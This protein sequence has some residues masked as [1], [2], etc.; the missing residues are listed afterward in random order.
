ME[1]L[2]KT[3]LSLR[4]TLVISALNT[5]ADLSEFLP[6]GA[7]DPYCVLIF[8]TLLKCASSTKKLLAETSHSTLLTY[9]A[10]SSYNPKALSLICSS[11]SDRSVQ[12]RI[13]A[14]SYLISFLTRHSNKPQQF[15]KKGLQVGLELVK[16]GLSRSLGDA[17]PKA[18]ELARQAFS[19]FQNTWPTEAQ[20]LLKSLDANARKQ[21]AHAAPDSSSTTAPT[22]AAQS[23]TRLGA[24]RTRAT[25]A[26]STTRPASSLKTLRT[27]KSCISLRAT[28]VT[29][30][31]SVMV[32]TSDRQALN[33]GAKP[34]TLFRSP[35]MIGLPLLTEESFYSPPRDLNTGTFATDPGISRI[36]RPP[37]IS[38]R[39]PSAANSRPASVA[40][41]HR[42]T[43]STSRSTPKA[44]PLSL[45]SP[46]SI[47]RNS[48]SMVKASSEGSEANS[49]RL[50]HKKGASSSQPTSSKYTMS[51]I[52][53]KPTSP[54]PKPPVKTAP[55]SNGTNESNP[56]AELHKLLDQKLSFNS[57]ESRKL[58]RLSRELPLPDNKIAWIRSKNF[59]RL[60]EDCISH[61]QTADHSS[62]TI[63][64]SISLLVSLIKNQ[65]ALCD[66]YAADILRTLVD[67]QRSK[68][69]DIS[70]L[71]EDA[72]KDFALQIDPVDCFNITVRHLHLCLLIE[73]GSL[74]EFEDLVTPTSSCYFV[75]SLV[76]PRLSQRFLFNV[77]SELDSLV[78]LGF[79]H[80][81]T[82][83]RHHVLALV[84]AIQSHLGPNQT[85]EEF[86]PR[87]TPAQLKL[88]NLY[89]ETDSFSP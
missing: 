41:H 22:L 34:S 82:T 7:L 49:P 19:I 18:R 73:K 25:E 71:A 78:G 4:T 69:R 47:S 51:T 29:R 3:L 40:G 89:I 42:S 52:V 60:M 20:I 79:H 68:L 13:Y 37:I 61:I 85:I 53:E 16:S 17:N 24:A 33:R 65:A 15:E 83:V 84:L 44:R 11:L 67:C 35:S 14:V 36:P 76:I 1:S 50:R 26:P 54:K 58:L 81:S 62:D 88:V 39:S 43:I 70:S 30:P 75:L 12:L 21:L 5:V 63:L 86:F 31:S 80:G 66:P 28:P 8:P 10:H 57:I 48:L 38:Q 64:N 74:P 2:N 23:S 9:L 6:D 56:Q 46:T 77:Q 72:L 55:V 87:L 32:T 27:Q 59:S 45:L